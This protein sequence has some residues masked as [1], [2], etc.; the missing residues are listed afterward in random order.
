MDDDTIGVLLIPSDR[1]DLPAR[2]PVPIG[3]NIQDNTSG[4]TS[5]VLGGCTS[6][7]S[8]PLLSALPC[9]WCAAVFCMPS[10]SYGVPACMAVMQARTYPDLLKSGYDEELF[11][12][13]CRSNLAYVKVQPIWLVSLYL[14]PGDQG[15]SMALT[16]RKNAEFV[17]RPWAAPQVSTGEVTQLGETRMYTS[18]SPSPDAQYLLVAWLER[19]YSYTVPCGRFPK[20]VQLWDRREPL[21]SYRDGGVFTYK[22]AD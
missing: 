13:Y 4:K 8:L 10:F 9:S 20:R 17:E 7:L 3:P 1:G 15:H 14:L 5:Q 18:F 16:G 2:P 12:Y 19:P 6:L 11:E 21:S 22:Q